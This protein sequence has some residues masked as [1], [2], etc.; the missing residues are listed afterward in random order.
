MSSNTES[1]LHFSCKPATRRSFFNRSSFPPPSMCDIHHM[2]RGQSHR[3]LPAQRSML[4]RFRIR[5]GFG[6]GRMHLDL[7]NLHLLQPKPATASPKAASRRWE[8]PGSG[9]SCCG[10]SRRGNSCLTL[11]C[12]FFYSSTLLAPSTLAL[13]SF[14]KK[15]EMAEK[16]P[17]GA[18][19]Q[20]PFQLETVL[21]IFLEGKLH[22][23]HKYPIFFRCMLHCPILPHLFCRDRKPHPSHQLQTSQTQTSPNSPQIPLSPV[24]LMGIMSS[25]LVHPNAF[26]EPLCSW[27]FASTANIQGT[28]SFCRPGGK[29]T[30][31]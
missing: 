16:Q 5:R 31:G 15:A 21:I 28:I 23:A 25:R 18:A 17:K 11:T 19:G 9:V 7:Q 8:K 3:A 29:R 14:S 10:W 2:L 20:T 1:Q 22:I 13:S 27:K 4:P 30:L 24:T 26:P 12:L 6:G